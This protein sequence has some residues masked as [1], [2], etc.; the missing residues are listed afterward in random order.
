MAKKIVVVGS[1][2]GGSAAAALLQTRGHEVTLLEQNE[3]IGG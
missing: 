1:G 2:P 3:F